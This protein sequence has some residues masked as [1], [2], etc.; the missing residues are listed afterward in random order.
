MHALILPAVPSWWVLILLIFGLAT[1]WSISLAMSLT[2]AVMR[3][4]YNGFSL[5][6]CGFGIDLSLP[7][8]YNWLLISLEQYFL[9]CSVEHISLFSLPP[10]SL[11]F[12]NL[13]TD[14]LFLL[15]HCI[16]MSLEAE[17][18]ISVFYF[19]TLLV[20]LGSLDNWSKVISGKGQPQKRGF[21]I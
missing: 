14:L 13:F 16:K 11:S 6:L 20:E 18:P 8:S 3:K 19:T 7:L 21:H 15:F 12:P 1:S 17:P 10:H 4:Y 2:L 9:L 5:T